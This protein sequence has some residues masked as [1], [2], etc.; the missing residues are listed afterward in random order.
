MEPIRLDKAQ[1]RSD[2]RPY[3]GY[4]P[5]LVLGDSPDKDVS[6]FRLQDGKLKLE[7]LQFRLKPRA[8][9]GK[10]EM[11]AV[12]G[13]AGQGHCQL[14]R[15]VFTLGSEVGGDG[16]SLSVVALADPKDVMKM[17]TPA[18]RAMPELFFENC[19]ARGRGSFVSVRA[20]RPFE[21]RADNCIAALNGSFCN[22]EASTAKE[23]PTTAA[24]IT[25]G[26][27][28]GV[29]SGN[30]LQLHTSREAKDLVPVIVRASECVFSA[31]AGQPLVHI[32]GEVSQVTKRTLSWDGRRNV[33]LN[34]KQ[35]LDQSKGEE[36]TMGAF[37]KDKWVA[38][39]NENDALFEG[40]RF[41]SAPP[42]I[43]RALLDTVPLQFRLKA[44]DEAELRAGADPARLL[45]PLTRG[46]PAPVSSADE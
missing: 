26:R 33:Y 28:T 23:L 6:M 13:I 22:V 16:A 45:T 43:D 17:G 15:C 36:N 11:Q 29:F 19:F 38:F 42:T 7:E 46:R 8:R 3:N 44:E 25:L 32:D 24:Q 2:D 1:R 34:F 20:S 10:D 31:S 12:I 35:L 30:L 21:L 40:I 41:L 4:H 37:N 27:M 5:V 9:E 18:P 39:T 14:K